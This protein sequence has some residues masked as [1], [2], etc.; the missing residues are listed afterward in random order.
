[1]LN[2]I[3]WTWCLPQSFLGWIVFK[4]LK[5]LGHVEEVRS[6]KSVRVVFIPPLTSKGWSGGS[7]GKF[8]FINKRYLQKEN[9]EAYDWLIQHEY[10]HTIQNYILGPLYLPIIGVSSGALFLLSRMNPKYRVK[11]H[12]IFPESWANKLA[13]IGPA[14]KSM[15]EFKIED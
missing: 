9:K 15:M 10:G 3:L 12:D 6:Y 8:I 7:A 13:K 2:L 5:T 11:Y 4:F 1:M 14:P